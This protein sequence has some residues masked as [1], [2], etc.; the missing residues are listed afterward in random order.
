VKIAGN[1]I[2]RK[3]IAPVVSM[4]PRTLSTSASLTTYDTELT[5][6]ISTRRKEETGQ[7]FLALSRKNERTDE[8]KH[9]R[10][11][12][13]PEAGVSDGGP[14]LLGDDERDRAASEK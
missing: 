7:Q 6:Y 5:D 14:H 8:I 12:I 1:W 2:H 3:C 13:L 10:G 9:S 4:L 11:E